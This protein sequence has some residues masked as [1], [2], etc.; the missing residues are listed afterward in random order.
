MGES[1][2]P[3]IRVFTDLENA[4]HSLAEKIVEEAGEAVAKRGRFTLALS[5]GKTPG[6]LYSRLASEYST[7]IEWPAVHL[8]WGDER[9][10]PQEHPDNNFAMAYPALI[11]KIPLPPQNIHCI[12][13]GLEN[14]GK[15]A[16][17][18]E[19][20]LRE[21]FRDSEA[22][23]FP[24][25]DVI[26]LGMGKDGHTASLFPGSP[27]L[28]EKNRWVVAVQAPSSFS[29]KNRITLTLPVINKSISVFF[30][31]SGSEKASVLKSIL[32]EPDTA[33]KLYP[34][35]MVKARRKLIWYVDEVAFKNISSL[36][37]KVVK[38]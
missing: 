32:E 26:L 33:G 35:A 9:Y 27:V 20:I 19:E 7:K 22:E 38:F 18:Y 28:D 24:T 29:P 4:S 11:S 25:F 21:F 13:T 34:A 5:G 1:L 15:A 3:E 30:L 17:T 36:P 10:V 14:P 37:Y 8:F 23:D 6:L 2:K 12:N 31:V 16:D